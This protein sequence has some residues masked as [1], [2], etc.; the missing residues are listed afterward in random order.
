MY[1]FAPT[2]FL[3][4]P[5]RQQIPTVVSDYVAMHFLQK[6]YH[7]FESIPRGGQ[8]LSEPFENLR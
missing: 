1:V 6:L 2:D 8:T 7:K 4:Q 3:P 5:Q